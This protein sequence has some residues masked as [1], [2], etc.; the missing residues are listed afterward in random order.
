MK[1]LEAWEA[2]GVRFSV[3]EG[4]FTVAHPR[5]MAVEEL[6]SKVEVMKAAWLAREWQRHLAE[7][8]LPTDDPRADLAA[9]HAKWA[10][11]LP[12]AHGLS[13]E[14]F[15]VLHGLR[16][17]GAGIVQGKLGCGEMTAAE[18]SGYRALLVPHGAMVAEVLRAAH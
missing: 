8:P 4:S 12:L 10:A 9:D 15:E 7:R 18:Y 16:C 13:A 17:L 14:L 3:A 5:G 11:V 6:R 2:L 1:T